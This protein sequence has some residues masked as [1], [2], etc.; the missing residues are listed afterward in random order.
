MLSVLWDG[1]VS[2]THLSMMIYHLI[3]KHTTI[4]KRNITNI[5]NV[6]QEDSKINGSA[7]PLNEACTTHHKRLDMSK[8]DTIVT[9]LCF[10]PRCFAG[11]FDTQTN[12]CIAIDFSL[13][14]YEPLIPDMFFAGTLGQ[15]EAKVHHFDAEKY[16]QF[17]SFALKGDENMHPH[18]QICSF[19]FF[20]LLFG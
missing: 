17:Y 8:G 14:I 9:C 7:W 15:K 13:Q 20:M 16:C 5:W 1:T 12:V 18:E 3:R 6:R 2:I 19:S 10:V 11:Q 4:A